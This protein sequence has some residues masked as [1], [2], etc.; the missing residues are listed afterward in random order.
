MAT[1]FF[2][3]GS[4][5]KAHSVPTLWTVTAL[6]LVSPSAAFSQNV[7]YHLL[8]VESI[9]IP[10]QGYVS[11]EFLGIR[12]LKFWEGRLYIGHGDG[13]ANTG[14]TEI[15]SVDPTSNE[16][17]NEFVTD[18]NAI[19]SFRVLD[20]RLVI[21]GGDRRNA[22]LGSIY[23]LTQDGWTQRSSILSTNH[24]L[25]ATVFNNKWYVSTGG[26]FFEFDDGQRYRIGTVMESPDSGET[27]TLSFSTP[28]SDPSDP[29]QY[30]VG[31]LAVFKDRLY[32]F[33]F[34]YGRMMLGEVPEQFQAALGDVSNLNPRYHYM[35][36]TPDALGNI[37]AV[38]YDGAQWTFADMVPEQNVSL[39]SGKVFSDYLLLVALTGQYL[40]VDRLKREFPPQASTRLYAFDGER[41]R[42]VSYGGGNIR[43]VLV[44]NDRLY[45]LIWKDDLRLIAET[46]DLETWTYHLLPDLMQGARTLEFDGESFYIG[47]ND[48]NLYRSLGSRS[49][50]SLHEVQGTAP[51]SFHGVADVPRQGRWYWAAITTWQDWGVPARLEAR[52]ERRNLVQV[53]VDNVSGFILF[54]SSSGVESE[55]PVRILINGH[56]VFEGTTAGVS[57]LQASL[58][59]EGAWEVE[60]VNVSRET[61]RPSDR[62]I[63]VVD[64]ELTLDGEQPG[65]A[66]WKAEVYRWATGADVA[67]AH[68]WGG[69]QFRLQP[70]DLS[71]HTLY[72]R[73]K[74]D[75][76][77]TF[78]LTGRELRSMIEF[79]IRHD[80]TWWHVSLAGVSATFELHDDPSTNR[81]IEWGL[82]DDS[83][84]VVAGDLHERRIMEGTFGSVPGYEDTGLSSFSAAVRWFETHNQVIDTPSQIRIVQRH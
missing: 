65:A 23:V 82:D 84:Y 29:T 51:R 38:V 54:L 67:F 68:Q 3:G 11:W 10:T 76:V 58:G 81:V 31:S 25:D 50:A 22:E 46:E 52:L 30:R 75:S 53:T 16:F 26:T 28:I 14:P 8:D 6:L 83:T 72:D 61:Y 15:L 12:D 32:G 4:L 37:D 24:L 79:N 48:G 73:L 49:I 77:Y 7:S 40:H 47:M 69:Q 43:D 60:P 45:L 64:T 34:H 18:E 63:G 2:D 17:V 71:L 62:I 74:A 59:S 56:L 1:I 57:A 35:L 70:G 42:S 19:G 33:P 36:Y 66:R 55:R 5:V 9:G 44:R 27:F 39:I 13:S 20:G 80:Q 21:P 41:S 78:R